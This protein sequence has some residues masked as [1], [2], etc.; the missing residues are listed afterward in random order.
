MESIPRKDEQLSN[1]DNSQKQ[2]VAIG[3]TLFKARR[4]QKKTC[5]NYSTL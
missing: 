2:Y 3:N 1:K 4:N 5:N